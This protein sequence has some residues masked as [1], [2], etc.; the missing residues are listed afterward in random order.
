MKKKSLIEFLFIIL[1]ILILFLLIPKPLSAVPEGPDIANLTANE[2][3]P[4]VTPKEVNI[5]GGRI[6]TYNLTS[7]S[8]NIRWKGFVGWVNGKFTLD[9][10]TGATIYDW[11]ITNFNGRVYATRNSTS[12]LWGNINCSNDSQLNM[13]NYRMNHTNV[14]DNIT[15]TF[16]NRSH[17]S[18]FVGSRSFAANECNFSLQTYINNASQT[19]Y[20]KE[21]ALQE[22]ENIIYATKI[23]AQPGGF[24]VDPYN[25]QMIVPENGAAGF[26]GLT[27]YYLYV[28]IV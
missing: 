26:S 16:S 17:A 1:A 8:K 19:T 4:S 7:K 5:S 6:A 25:F 23:E 21:T 27:P 28:E 13:E 2:T 11:T 14:N 18:F 3:K 24:D 20:F 12:L 9:D 22:G 15:T 10:S